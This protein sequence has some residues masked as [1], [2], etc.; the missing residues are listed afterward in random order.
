MAQIGTL[1]GV[2]FE[3][4]SEKVQTFRDYARKSAARLATHEIIGQK[5]VMEFL[6]PGLDSISFTI[7]LS[8]Y[9]GVNPKEEAEKLRTIMQEG[10]AVD[11]IV[12]DAPISENKWIIESVEETVSAHD[13]KGNI[14]R[15]DLSLTLQEYIEGSAEDADH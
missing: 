5:P 12:A 13:E 14:I 4:S 7:S 9:F 2:V 15:S 6:G 3:A 1:G 8:A 10:Q 11:F